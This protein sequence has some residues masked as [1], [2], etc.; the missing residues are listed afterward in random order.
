[1]I[2][3]ISALVIFWLNALPPSPSVEGNLSPCQIVTALTIDY[4]K[5]CCLQFGEYAQVH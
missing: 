4:A 2:V 3:E 1:M 5:H